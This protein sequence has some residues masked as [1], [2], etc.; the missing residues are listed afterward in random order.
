MAF[1]D[2]L[3][4]LILG[5]GE[6][7]SNAARARRSITAQLPESSWQLCERRSNSG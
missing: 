4:S 5:F 6:D 2:Q 3:G 7:Q 1:V